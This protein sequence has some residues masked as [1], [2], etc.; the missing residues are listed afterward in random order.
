MCIAHLHHVYKRTWKLGMDQILYD[1]TAGI[2]RYGDSSS[3]ENKFLY[4][5]GSLAICTIS[6]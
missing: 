1:E 3:G 5:I 6:V 4:R 2:Q